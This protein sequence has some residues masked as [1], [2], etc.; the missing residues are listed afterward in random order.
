LY[1]SDSESEDDEEEGDQ[2]QKGRPIKPLAKGKGAK[3]PPQQEKAGRTKEKQTG[4]SYIRDE[5]D[6]PMDLL[7][8]SI[9]GGITCER[10]G[11]AT[12]VHC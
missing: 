12:R 7:S 8:R 10:R 6:E 5:G 1:N 4:Q 11:L 3:G 2:P 9:A